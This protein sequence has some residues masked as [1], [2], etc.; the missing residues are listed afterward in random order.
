MYIVRSR[1]TDCKRLR[2]NHPSVSL[3]N[4]A[5]ADI[6]DGGATVLESESGATES[7]SAATEGVG[8]QAGD[9]GQDGL[10]GLPDRQ[11]QE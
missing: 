7:A 2:S 10:H 4:W 1:V 8:H 3:P 6:K 11:D 5:G 9:Q